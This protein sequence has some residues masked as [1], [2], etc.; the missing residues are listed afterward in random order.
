MTFGVYSLVRYGWKSINIEQ[1]LSMVGIAIGM[2]MIVYAFSFDDKYRMY[3]G[4]SGYI[5]A[6]FC[7]VTYG[8]F[9]Y[10][11]V[12]RQ[13]KQRVPQKTISDFVR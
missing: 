4:I 11:P 6:M 8:L 5:L 12:L 3:V 9:K 13:S 1:K 10:F 2:F 7:S